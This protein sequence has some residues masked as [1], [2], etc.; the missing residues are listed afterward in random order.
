[1][2]TGQYAHNHGVMGNTPPHGGFQ[3]FRDDETLAVWLTRAGYNTAL[4]GK[5][6]NGYDAPSTRTYLP[7]GWTQWQ[8][9]VIGV[10][11]YRSFT[12][13]ENGRLV[14]YLATRSTTSATEG[15]G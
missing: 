4:L 9:P 7:P 1:M 14:H 13:N 3:A 5:Y 12:M 8:V 10:Y 6:L 15:S 11:N 2:L